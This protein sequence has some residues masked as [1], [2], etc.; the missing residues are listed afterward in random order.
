MC[1]GGY[2]TLMS[3]PAPLERAVDRGQQLRAMADDCGR[4]AGAQEVAHQ[5]QHRGVA[6]QVLRCAAPAH[7]AP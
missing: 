3:S 1:P 2:L 6:P 5:V 4:L 7:R